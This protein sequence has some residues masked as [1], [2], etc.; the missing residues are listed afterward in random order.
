M[1]NKLTDR[2]YPAKFAHFVVRREKRASMVNT[3]DTVIITNDKNCTETN[4][5]L[6]LTW[7]S[8]LLSVQY[9]HQQNVGQAFFNFFCKVDTTQTRLVKLSSTLRM[10]NERA[11][12]PWSTS[13]TMNNH[14]IIRTT[15]KTWL[16]YCYNTVQ[17]VEKVH[18]SHLDISEK[19]WIT[20]IKAKLNINNTFML[21]FK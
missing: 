4:V 9:S 10:N 3:S 12:L 19:F 18:P 6:R 16:A 2:W 1:K 20:K 8:M 21:K 15:T 5:G 13:T 14:N 7:E 17:F 11:K